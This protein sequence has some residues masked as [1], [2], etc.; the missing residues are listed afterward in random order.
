[1]PRIDDYSMKNLFYFSFGHLT[2]V[3]RC[4]CKIVSLFVY[5]QYLFHLV[6]VML[7]GFVARSNTEVKTL[8][9]VVIIYDTLKI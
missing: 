2:I 4:T 8:V 3:L 9:T 6:E 7:T 1:M 5:V